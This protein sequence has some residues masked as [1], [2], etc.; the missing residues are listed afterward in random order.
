MKLRK[1]IT[2]RNSFTYAMETL[3]LVFVTNVSVVRASFKVFYSLSVTDKSNISTY[4]L[5]FTV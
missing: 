2:A 3:G 1:K 5:Y 4:I